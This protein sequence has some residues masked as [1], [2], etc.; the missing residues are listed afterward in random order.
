MVLWVSEGICAGWN[1]FQT[2]V[3]N[4]INYEQFCDDLAPS[5]V[6]FQIFINF[7]FYLTKKKKKKN[8]N[9]EFLPDFKKWNW[10][11]CRWTKLMKGFL[12]QLIERQKEFKNIN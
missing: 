9:R 8:T 10:T 5:N 2:D 6:C 1:K 12:F 3:E 7:F 11:L 4:I